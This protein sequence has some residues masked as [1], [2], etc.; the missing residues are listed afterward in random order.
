MPERYHEVA[1]A[2]GYV[3]GLV[4]AA[5]IM[6]PDTPLPEIA[7]HAFSIALDEKRFSA[8]P[9]LRNLIRRACEGEGFD[10]VFEEG[11]ECLK[12]VLKEQYPG[13]CPDWVNE[14]KNERNGPS[15]VMS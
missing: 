12:A 1:E 3:R 5:R 2:I 11:L 14:S 6:S 15:L 10:W 7:Q 4:D 13:I 8:T 9:K